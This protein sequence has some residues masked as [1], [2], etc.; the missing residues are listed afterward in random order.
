ML[1]HRSYELR[2]KFTALVLQGPFKTLLSST[3]E[4]VSH[5]IKAVTSVLRLTATEPLSLQ[6]IPV[7]G[8]VE[9]APPFVHNLKSAALRKV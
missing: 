4:G 7:L 3:L 9:D 6:L 2:V 1:N 8:E 5:I